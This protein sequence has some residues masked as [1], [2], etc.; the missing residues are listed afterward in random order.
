MTFGWNDSQQRQIK[1]W[2]TR[3][4]TS[5]YSTVVLDQSSAA[6][7]PLYDED[8]NLLFF[9]SKGEN[10]VKCYELMDEGLT[11][12]FEVGT[13]DSVKGLCMMPKWCLDVKRCEFDRL[14]QLTYQSLLTIDMTLP[15]RQ[16]GVEFQADV[17]PPTFASHPSLTAEKF[18]SGG[19]ANP[20]EYNLEA[21]FEGNPP[22]LCES[23]KSVVIPPLAQELEKNHTLGVAQRS[24]EV[25]QIIPLKKN[26]FECSSSES[27]DDAALQDVHTAPKHVDPLSDM[28]GRDVI[29]KETRMREMARKLRIFHQEIAALRKALEEKEVEMLKVLEELQD[30]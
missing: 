23:V 21:L 27:G 16:G 14:Y 10:N 17:F 2:D 20:R 9:G 18:F 19:D 12:S 26:T 25:P 30:I 8:T 1:L 28:T 29:Q 22:Q 24:S 11:F 6:F 4:M 3:K 5:A 7:M 15:R 13:A